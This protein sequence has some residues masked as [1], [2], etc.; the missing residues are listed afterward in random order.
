MP[1][2]SLFRFGQPF[3]SLEHAMPVK[4]GQHA[5]FQ[6]PGQPGRLT[7]I[8]QPARE[9]RR[10]LAAIGEFS[11][12]DPAFLDGQRARAIT[13]VDG[14]LTQT[15]QRDQHIIGHHRC[16][17]AG[18]GCGFGVAGIG[19][20]TQSM[21]IGE[22]SMPERGRVHVH[23]A[24]GIGQR[25]AANEVG[26]NLRG[27]H[28]QH[29]KAVLDGFAAAIG[30]RA[31][32]RSTLARPVD[33]HQPMAELEVDGVPLDVI[34]QRR[35]IVRH[36][37]QHATG[38]EE[39]R[40][41]LRQ[42]AGFQPVVTRQ[43]HGLLWR[44]GA[45]D[46]HG[47]LSKQRAPLLQALHQLPGIGCQVIAIVGGHAVGTQRLDQPVDGR[48]VQL[49][50]G[51]GHQLLIAKRTPVGERQ[52]IVLRFEGRHRSL[53]PLHTFGNQRRHAAC[54]RLRRE[55]ARADHGPARLVIVGIGRVDQ[56]D[57][58]GSI[59]GEQACGGGDT[60]STTT[61]DQDLTGSYR[62]IHHRVSQGGQRSKSIERD[63]QVDDAVVFRLGKVP[64]AH[65]DLHRRQHQHRHIQRHVTGFTH[66]DERVF[67]YTV[68]NMDVAGALFG[69]GGHVFQL[70]T[71]GQVVVAH[72]QQGVRRQRQQFVNG[73][74]QGARIGSGKV[75]TGGAVI[76][77]E[78]RVAH[79]RDR[80]VTNLH[81]VTH[82]RRCMPGRMHGLDLKCSKGKRGVVFQQHIEL[83]AIA[84]KVRRRVEQRAK[85]F[86]H[87]GDVAADD[88]LSAKLLFQVRRSREV[89]S[90][91][92]GFENPLHRSPQRLYPADHPVGR[93]GPGAARLGVVIE[94]A[95]D[96]RALLASQVHHQVADGPGMAVEEGF[97]IKFFTDDHV[98]FPWL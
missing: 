39:L 11:Q 91:H 52:G 58:Q 65:V 93:L 98:Q 23:P 51:A 66:A 13:V 18:G 54:R 15:T 62:S 61:N 37:K 33:C 84:G 43:V 82:A 96:Q 97:D 25:A 70:T 87:G 81:Q 1:G 6:P 57:L 35:Y 8:Q 2:V 34:H 94:H 41:D 31:N 16:L 19:G 80:G 73:A 78:Q 64:A 53:D 26:G 68:M 28:V 30:L 38:V 48:P 27:H 90:M 42:T 74:V 67:I 72:E 85:G 69:D 60:G 5:F 86:L 75:A 47:R 12:Y 4:Y 17:L 59:T 76:G 36:T 40:I 7:A 56:G 44:T 10:N 3:T 50:A 83:A 14:R 32:K 49:Q 45:F 24:C 88:D 55:N 9:A 79:K 22:L 71:V 95:V 46:R 89:I 77:H 21:N 20:I 63:L 29:F 92:M